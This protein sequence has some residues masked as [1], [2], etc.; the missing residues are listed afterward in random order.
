MIIELIEVHMEDAESSY[1]LG[2]IYP[3]VKDFASHKKPWSWAVAANISCQ[4]LLT[5]VL[6][7]LQKYAWVWLFEIF[8]WI[9]LW[10]IGQAWR[11]FGLRCWIFF[12]SFALCSR[13]EPQGLAKKLLNQAATIDKENLRCLP[14]RA[15]ITF[16]H[17]NIVCPNWRRF[18]ISLCLLWKTP[19]LSRCASC[20][21][22]LVKQIGFS[23]LLESALRNWSMPCPLQYS[24][25][26]N[27]QG[28][29]PLHHYI[30]K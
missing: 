12:S 15:L 28:F 16:Q 9:L 8:L 7:W 1:L 29:P 26:P 11:R 14:N 25:L 30:W 21:R 20:L 17:S 10:N 13:K 3:A 22:P 18:V 27:L 4:A 23:L 24:F 19:V 2:E 5:S 6:I